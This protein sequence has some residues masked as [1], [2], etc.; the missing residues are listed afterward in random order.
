[1]GCGCTRLNELK[2]TENGLEVNIDSGEYFVHQ[3]HTACLAQNSYY[4]ES[5]KEALIIDPVRDPEMYLEVLQKRG[6]KLKH[7]LETHFHEDYVSGHLELNK[8]TGAKIV[9]GPNA[10]PGYDAY[11]AK[12]EELMQLGKIYIK[13]MHTP[14]HT[15]ESTSFL[16]LDSNKIPKALFTGDCVLLCEVGRSDLEASTGKSSTEMAGYLYDSVQKLKKLPDDVIIFPGHGY[17]S[18]SGKKIMQGTSSS[19]GEQKK[20]N[21]AFNNSLSKKE[22]IEKSLTGLPAPAKY[23]LNEINLNKKGYGL[24]ENVVQ[25][26]WK[27]IPPEQFYRSFSKNEDYVVIDTRDFTKAVKGFLRG[28][29]ILSLRISSVSWSAELF[30]PEQK[31]ILITDQGKEKESIIRLA[32]TGYEGV[33]GFVEGGYEGLY[34]YCQRKGF[35]EKFSSAKVPVLFQMKEFLENNKKT[36]ILDVRDKYEIVK[37]GTIG[38]SR[39]I[40]IRNLESKVDQYLKE[41]GNNSIAIYSITGGKAAIAVSILA[42]HGANNMNFMGGFLNVMG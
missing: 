30:A 13:V 39:W 6:D 40:T 8:K 42:K 38:D 11:T 2:R 37:M 23:F 24:V 41:I 20:I 31:I 27:P 5:N 15:M 4:I 32:M 36:E 18:S 3:F 33:L 35:L 7:V 14:G 12:D 10:K 21:Y 1:M 16:L 22:F 25:K 28:S 29:Y 19:I 34:D 26:S 17:G 9:F